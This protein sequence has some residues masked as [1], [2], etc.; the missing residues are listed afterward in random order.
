MTQATNQEDLSPPSSA[1]A[2]RLSVSAQDDDREAPASTSEV[3]YLGSTSF[4]EVFKA[5]KHPSDSVWLTPLAQ[6]KRT[7]RTTA[8]YQLTSEHMAPGVRLLNLL[9]DHAT[10]KETLQ[11]YYA[12]S[13]IVVVPW[14]TLEKAIDSI[15]QTLRV[16]YTTKAQR[17]AL[18]H[19]I[20]TKTGE[21]LELDEH[22]TA[23]TLHE[24]F[25][26][27]NLRWEI[28]GILFTYLALGMRTTE[29]YIAQKAKKRQEFI[30]ELVHASNICASFCDRA[31]SV[32]DLLVWLYGI[33]PKLT[34]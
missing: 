23:E 30:S 2:T 11:N 15:L 18:V 9:S 1:R 29:A 19:R 22:V 28:L 31:E 14:I 20:F 6:V 25:T 12:I 32:N 16:D 33:S 3:G 10:M 7:L 21:P 26:G 17:L 4:S 13:P 34:R 5:S 24:S 27:D 8:T